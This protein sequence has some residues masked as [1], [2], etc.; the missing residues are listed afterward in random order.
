M[1]D[2]R[3]LP[4]PPDDD[5]LVAR[6]NAGQSSLLWSI[7]VADLLTPVAALKRLVRLT[8]NGR[9]S[10]LLESVEGGTSRGRYSVI[11]LLPD[12]VWRCHGG[13]AA[14]NRTPAD[15]AGFESVTGTPLESLR[16][17]MADSR[18][19]LP[20]G[21]PPM[22]GGLFGYLGYDMVRQME[23]L[24]NMPPDDLGLPEGTMLRPALF[25]I[26]DTV[27]DELILV[28]SVRP[29]GAH[30]ACD[31][32]AAARA[33]IERARSVLSEPLAI[34]DMSP[35]GAIEIGP[36]RST[37]TPEAFCDAVR[38]IQDYIAAGDAFQVV[39][40]QRFSARF[41]LPPLALYRALRRINPAPFLFYFDF[42]AF[43]LVGSSP[44]ILV[45][46]REGVMTVRPLAGTRPRGATQAEDLALERELL[47][48]QKELAEHL[49]LIDLGRND[50]GRVAEMGSVKV[51][52]K[53][54]IERFSHVMHISS[55][56]EGRLRPE[57]D[58]LDALVAG[59]PAGTLTGAPKIRAMEIIDEIEPTRR[60]TYAGCI[61]Y[62]GPDG[63]M[64]TCIG[65]RMAVVK[66]GEIHVQA[67]CGVVADSVPEAEHAETQHKARALFRAAEEAVR[68][69]GSNRAPLG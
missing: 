14:L 62:F 26:F 46:L 6:L 21:M 42:G 8:D 68:F 25:A 64:D 39:P 17:V 66:D 11:G 34:A 15:D 12:L 50:V 1:S 47:A 38:R 4:P 3:L 7:E 51:R 45:R 31:T 23:H 20:E 27:R 60:A 19:D 5:V 10:F 43:S 56:V 55:T 16:A 24:P 40:S 13:V 57:F 54:V 9:Y 22:A 59:F 67:G 63:D 37:F 44:E 58:A 49:M 41:S 53:F 69:A 36:Q 33:L 61:G 2:T 65:L 48:D 52:E 30:T 28:A 35:S 32:V 18:I 29:G